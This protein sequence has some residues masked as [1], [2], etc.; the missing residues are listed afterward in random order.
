M[1][2][3]HSPAVR[4]ANMR[5]IRHK[6]TSPELQVRRLLFARGFRFRLHVRS[7]PGA[8]DIVL[9]KHRVAIFVHGCFWHGHG[10]HLFKIPRTR[11]DFW[12]GKIQ[13]N[14]DRDYRNEAELLA[15]GWRVL[16]IWEC[17]LKGKQ[18]RSTVDLIDEASEWILAKSVE[19]P[20]LVIRHS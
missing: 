15:A 8:P 6:N 7:L 2:D 4:S 11:T 3:V 17:A 9:P 18:K 10:C 1:A 16:S 20:S 5:A 13:Q 12:L 19:V 14:R